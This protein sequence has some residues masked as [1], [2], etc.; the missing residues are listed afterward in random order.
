MDVS[1]VRN[2]EKNNKEVPYFVRVDLSTEVIE[3]K[4]VFHIPV[5]WEPTVSRGIIKGL[6]NAE[7]CGFRVEGG[8]FHQIVRLVYKL[9][10]G[11]INMAR[12]PTYIFVARRS[13][14]I[15]PVYTI[16]DEVLV[17]TPGGP[18]FRHV[19]LAKVRDYLSEYLHAVGEL[20]SPGKS[21]ALHVRGV[22]STNL[23]LV[24]PVFYLKKRVPGENDFWAPVFPANDGRSIYTY[25]ASARREVEIADGQEVLTLREIVAE[26]LI[27]DKRLKNGYDLRPDR[28][29]P[30]YWARLQGTLTK[31]PLKL[32]MFD[33]HTGTNGSEIDLYKNGKLYLATEPRGEENRV[34]LFIGKDP[35]DLRDRLVQDYLRRGLISTS[36]AVRVSSTRQKGKK[37][38]S[39]LDRLLAREAIEGLTGV[40][41]EEP[42]KRVPALTANGGKTV[43]EVEAVEA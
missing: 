28:L 10:P 39:G 9:L 20:G 27:A 43:E 18:V 31:N 41:L 5:Y 34:G 7:I 22:R 36:E 14:R 17:T 37:E 16:G 11:L 21:E 24:R 1:L 38:L 33:H 13:R 15:Y 12:L 32:A 40:K 6:Y 42:L 23:S 30:D 8:N 4:E 25:A 19:E 29:M 2:I 26:A 35:A 3:P